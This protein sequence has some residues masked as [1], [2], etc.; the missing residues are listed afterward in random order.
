MLVTLKPSLKPSRGGL[1]LDLGGPTSASLSGTPDFIGATLT[2]DGVE[3]T[4]SFDTGS[5]NY[6]T[7][8]FGT[9]PQTTNTN[10]Y[11]YKNFKKF[12]SSNGFD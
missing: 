2:I 12:Q 11:V 8:V 5:P 1:N 4:I 3:N 10:V 6:I 7:K 9:D